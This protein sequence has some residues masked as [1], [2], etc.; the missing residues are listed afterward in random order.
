MVTKSS[1]KVTKSSR[2]DTKSSNILDNKN[3]VILDGKI[4]MNRKKSSS[5]Q[6]QHKNWKR[7][8]IPAV[9]V[10]YPVKDKE[11]QGIGGFPKKKRKKYVFLSNR[12]H[13]RI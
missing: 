10:K 5:K 9:T 8:H 4:S 2:K 7:R 13:R 6:F 3:S 12:D 1:H 11:R